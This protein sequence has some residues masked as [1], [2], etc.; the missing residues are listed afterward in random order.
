MVAIEWLSDWAGGIIVAVIIGTI[1]EMILPEGN[2]KKYIKVVIGMYVLFT[3]V[4]PLITKVTGENVEVSDI[5]ELDKYIEDAEEASK[6]QNSIEDNNQSSI[7]N[8]YSSGLK[9]DIKAKIEAK[10]YVVNSVDIG[11]ADDETYAI[12]NITLE[13]EEKDEDLQETENNIE[14][15]TNNVIE[16]VQAVEKVEVDIND[17]NTTKEN[18]QEKEDKKSKLLYSKEKE[19]KEYLS[20]VYE[21]KEENI[22]IN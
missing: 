20:S 6:V 8:I 13:V 12:E 15:T 11:I 16:Q 21:V 9:D 17:K 14:N 3:I 5:L 19:L 18:A 22:T 10:G 2:C 4:S 1:I 7:M